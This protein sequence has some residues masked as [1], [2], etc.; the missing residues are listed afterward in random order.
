MRKIQ[1]GALRFRTNIKK[2]LLEIEHD[3]S[4]F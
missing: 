2:T 4:N 1:M 3:Q